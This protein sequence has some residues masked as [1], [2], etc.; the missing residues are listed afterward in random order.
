MY[1]RPQQ[2]QVPVGA[3][4]L[5]DVPANRRDLPVL[6]NPSVAVSRDLLGNGLPT[7]STPLPNSVG[8]PPMSVPY[9]DALSGLD[10]MKPAGPDMTPAEKGET[11]E[12]APDA[13]RA[14]AQREAQELALRQ[15]AFAQY[16]QQVI[17]LQQARAA[18]REKAARRDLYTAIAIGSVASVIACVATVMYRR[19]H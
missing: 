18:E 11:Q 5:A 2:L 16:Q 17:A 13:A 14:K 1:A 15:L 7:V 10:Q 4:Q 3:G 12:P 19:S 6:V 8:S 9:V